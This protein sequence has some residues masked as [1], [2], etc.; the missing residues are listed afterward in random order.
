MNRRFVTLF[1]LSL[2]AA[3]VLLIPQRS[4]AG[5]SDR[6]ATFVHPNP[7]AEGTTFQLTMPKSARIRIAVY[8]V[9]GELMQVLYEGEHAQGEYDVYWNGLDMNGNPVPRGVYVCTL[10]SE[11]KPIQWVKVIKALK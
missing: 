7:F 6:T 4:E 3:T 9:L 1:M 10:H 5:G 11:G 2:M 8:N